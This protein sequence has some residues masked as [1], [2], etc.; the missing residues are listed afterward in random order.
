MNGDN[1]RADLSVV[2]VHGIGQQAVGST[3]L[4]WV[5]PILRCLREEIEQP[6]APVQFQTVQLRQAPAV[7]RVSFGHERTVWEFREAYWADS[8]PIA[9]AG[10]VLSWGGNFASRAA[11][12]YLR[13][14]SKP[15]FRLFHWSRAI[16]VGETN[17]DHGRWGKLAQVG[18]WFLTV[19]V[20]TYLALFFGAL[21][22]VI[23]ILSYLAA[24][25]VLVLRWLPVIGPKASALSSTLV[26]SIGDAYVFTSRPV[27]TAAMCAKVSEAID[28]AT[29]NSKKVCV[30]AHS[31]GAAVAARALLEKDLA[32]S[33]VPVL[34]TVGAAVNLL[35]TADS[36][37]QRWIDGK[38]AFDWINLWSAWDPVPS[39]PMG[40]RA[41][42]VDR[43]PAESGTAE[44]FKRKNQSEL[45]IED[46]VKSASAH[47]CWPLATQPAD[48]TQAGAASSLLSV[49]GRQIA[50]FF[51]GDGRALAPEELK[52]VS[53][54]PDYRGPEEWQV[55]NRASLFT[56]H[57]SYTA[58]VEQVIRP[59]TARL[60]SVSDLA[61]LEQLTPK[62]QAR[63][64]RV[65]S[66][67]LARLFA[68][69]AAVWAVLSWKELIT[70]SP[71]SAWIQNWVPDYLTDKLPDDLAPLLGPSIEGAVRAP[72]RLAMFVLAVVVLY[73][74][75]FLPIGWMW[76]SWTTAAGWQQATGQGKRRGLLARGVAFRVLY[77]AMVVFVSNR[78]WS[79]VSG[80]ARDHQQP[81]VVAAQIGAA[82]AVVAILV[83]A[84]LM[85]I[86]G[87][88][89]TAVAANR[90]PPP[91]DWRRDLR[92]RQ[93]VARRTKRDVRAINANGATARSKNRLR[94]QT[95]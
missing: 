43:V 28:E 33:R 95:A 59:I 86:V 25:L 64:R 41:S 57:T 37:I 7:V 22:A 91:G 58:N 31:Q 8:F 14:F 84:V 35:N 94:S 78:V 16:S 62:Q 19:F 88:R 1:V 38:G 50:E 61:T 40:I 60:L 18:A 47:A 44:E 30:I 12:R 39:G 3:L 42:D 2:I 77:L 10:E 15:G 11:F 81:T 49:L 51:L 90:T 80:L 63:T 70:T 52:A 79:T 66:L 55:H 56:D 67:G 5:E 83:L 6:G 85:P 45:E 32:R 89:P 54:G 21:L 23:A 46:A 36:P 65:H 13:Q 87:I 73:C 26:L 17:P 72:V 4:G 20:F 53:G 29:R 71:G 48:R 69:S 68:A 76:S 27:H 92:P 75:C 82:L 74:L 9:T 24:I 34:F 93:R